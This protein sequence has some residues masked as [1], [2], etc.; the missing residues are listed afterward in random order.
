MSMLSPPQFQDEGSAIASG[1]WC[2]SDNAKLG[3]IYPALP[4][5]N[6]QYLMDNKHPSSIPM[7]GDRSSFS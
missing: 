2:D 7:V 6:S 1:L 4:L 3:T 5:F